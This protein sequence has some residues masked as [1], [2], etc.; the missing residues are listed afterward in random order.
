V[1]NYKIAVTNTGSLNVDSMKI[2]ERAL[3]IDVLLFAVCFV[4]RD[5]FAYSYV[6][7]EGL[8]VTLAGLLIVSGMYLLG[9]EEGQK[10]EAEKE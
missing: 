5:C 1:T 6:A 7:L 8:T 10:I 2:F 4:S 9:Y 3:L